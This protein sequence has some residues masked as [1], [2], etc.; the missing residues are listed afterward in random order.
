MG[1][2]AP[3]SWA[4]LLGLALGT[5]ALL[6]G[7]AGGALGFLCK[8]Q[9]AFPLVVWLPLRLGTL[10]SSVIVPS[11]SNVAQSASSRAWSILEIPP[12]PTPTHTILPQLYCPP[13]ISNPFPPQPS[14]ICRTPHRLQPW[15]PPQ[16]PPHAHHCIWPAARTLCVITCDHPVFARLMCNVGRVTWNTVE[17]WRPGDTGNKE[18]TGPHHYWYKDTALLIIYL[19]LSFTQVLPPAPSHPIV[20]CFVHFTDLLSQKKCN[21]IH[22]LATFLELL[23]MFFVSESGTIMGAWAVPVPSPNLILIP[24]KAVRSCSDFIRW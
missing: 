5:A 22:P 20:W 7:Q 10:P 15:R 6:S 8:N 13:H 17:Q 21:S 2:L 18:E 11:S 14:N 16:P 12:P 23:C 3:G 24:T 1:G 4:P 9:S 19:F